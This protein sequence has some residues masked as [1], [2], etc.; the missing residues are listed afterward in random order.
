MKYI[1]TRGKI[2]PIS[3]KETVLM[4]LAEDGGLILPERI[5]VIP[6]ESL[7]SWASLSYPE[8]A[9]EVFSL[10]ADDIP[11]SDG[12]LLVA[13]ADATFRHP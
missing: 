11:G 9:V 5:P 3:F 6:R 13:R 12:R 8:L 4:G 7:E 2:A 1:S 10:F